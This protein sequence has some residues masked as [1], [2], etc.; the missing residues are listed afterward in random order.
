MRILSAL[1]LVFMLGTVVNTAQAARNVTNEL[2]SIQKQ[3]QLVK[4]AQQALNK[5]LGSVGKSLKK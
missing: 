3:R 5:E 1:L 2:Q 4:H